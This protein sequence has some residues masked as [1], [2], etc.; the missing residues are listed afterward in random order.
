MRLLAIFAVFS[1][2]T[3]RAAEPAAPAQQHVRGVITRAA[4]DV[5]DIE[6]GPGHTEQVRI[7]P[8]VQVAQVEP[9]EQ[10]AI[11]QG[12]FIGTTAVPQADGTLRAV[13]VHVFPESMRGAGEGHRPWD[14]KPKSSMTNATVSGLKSS[15]ARKSSMTNAT[16]SGMTSTGGT[17]TLTLTY[18]GG[19]QTVVVPPKTPIVKVEPG[20]RS[21][22]VAGAHVIAFAAPDKDGA[23]VAQRLTVGKNGVVPPM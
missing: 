4:G 11:A 8:N 16:V 7:P 9:A 23:L 12:A 15:P 13:E 21:L 17:R 6:T 20:N 22:L 1:S 3:A 5:L 10:S 2:L 14:L 18:P 19:T